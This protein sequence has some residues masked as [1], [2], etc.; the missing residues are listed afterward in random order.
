MM[1][2]G[3]GLAALMVALATFG[4][5]RVAKTL[6]AKIDGQNAKIDGQNTKIDAQHVKIDSALKGKGP[7]HS[8]P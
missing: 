1:C 8:H 5:D 6:D 3:V 2:L 7:F 4:F